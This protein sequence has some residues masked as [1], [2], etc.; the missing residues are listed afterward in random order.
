[1]TK[2]P[3]SRLSLALLSA[4]MLS[5]GT[6]T[7][8]AQG[9]REDPVELNRI[10]AVVNSEAITSTELKARLVTVERQLRAQNVQLPP[11]QVLEK[12]LLELHHT[13]QGHRGL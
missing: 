4:F 2:H 10:V 7:A 11:P 12:Q 8:W 5:A 1:M 9:T 6:S 13:I 3:G